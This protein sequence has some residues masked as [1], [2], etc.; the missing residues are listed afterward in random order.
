[1]MITE[2]NRSGRLNAVLI[3]A[4]PPAER[5]AMA[6]SSGLVDTRNVFSI[7]GS[8]SP[9]KSCAKAFSGAGPGGGGAGAAAAAPG[10]PAGAAP[11]PPGATLPAAANPGDMP[12]GPRP[13]LP[14]P[15]PSG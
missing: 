6:R 3:V 15:R 11:R 5:P 2:R 14:P 7:V 12:D 10:A 9:T 1:M 8:R 4:A 13:R